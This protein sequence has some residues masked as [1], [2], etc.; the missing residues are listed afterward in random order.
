MNTAPT[1]RATSPFPL[2][3]HSR[4][5]E[6]S[7]AVTEDAPDLPLEEV[8]EAADLL[9]VPDTE[10]A[11]EKLHGESGLLDPIS[12]VSVALAAEYLGQ[13]VCQVAASLPQSF[14]TKQGR[15]R[16]RSKS[17][18]KREE[19]S[20]GKHRKRRKKKKRREGGSEDEDDEG[21]RPKFGVKDLVNMLEPRL[22]QDEQSGT[23][24]VMTREQAVMS[25]KFEDDV[26]K[27]E[28]ES[29][30]KRMTSVKQIVQRISSTRT[31]ALPE[32]EQSSQ[33]RTAVVQDT[34][35][36]PD[37]MDAKGVGRVIEHA[38]VK[39]QPS[40][41]SPVIRSI[42]D[43]SGKVEVIQGD[44]TTVVTMRNKSRARPPPLP[45]TTASKSPVHSEAYGSGSSE[46]Q[47]QEEPPEEGGEQSPKPN[48]HSRLFKL[49]QDSDYTDSETG[50]TESSSA[51]AQMKEATPATA[52]EAE[53]SLGSVT[54]QPKLRRH[55]LC[56]SRESDRTS[57][58]SPHE[59]VY[60]ASPPTLRKEI[61][62]RR[63]MS[64]N[65]QT[66]YEPGAEPGPL[67][68]STPISPKRPGSVCF[69][70]QQQ[71]SSRVWSYTQDEQQ[72]HQQ[73]HHH[74][75]QQQQQLT[76]H[77]DSSY[78]SQSHSQLSLDSIATPDGFRAATVSREHSFR[79]LKG[80]PAAGNLNSPKMERRSHVVNSPKI[81]MELQ[82]LANLPPLNMRGMR[83]SFGG[84]GKV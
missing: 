69:T 57:Q 4:E 34:A 71:A 58:P 36:I 43:A 66:C 83:G 21:Y 10:N 40:K 27:E 79:S 42:P 35:D 47:N 59:F 74:Y 78:Y 55:S 46:H 76:V 20:D 26:A 62:S 60:K 1:T 37:P 30:T 6:T 54:K 9:V 41:A 12:E 2:E 52:A 23:K 77:D 61:A 65:L 32:C 73:L 49:L 51:A 19:S 7:K 31:E 45:Q 81:E 11:V 25:K 80:D 84:G 22:F 70:Q 48:R 15:V 56:G 8:E 14:E 29:G 72:Q 75:H 64:L 24:M 16:S 38:D 39:A 13:K 63:F 50:D 18:S 33:P 3:P 82:E 28:E 67:D 53:S 44:T 68:L 5:I 17:S